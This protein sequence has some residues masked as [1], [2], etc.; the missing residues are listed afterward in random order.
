MA[1]T[2]QEM[3]SRLAALEDRVALL[4]QVVDALED[5]FE[6]KIDQWTDWLRVHRNLLDVMDREMTRLRGKGPWPPTV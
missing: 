6:L 5:R 1:L 2:R 3:E 4:S